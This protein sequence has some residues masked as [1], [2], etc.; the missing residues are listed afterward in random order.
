MSKVIVPFALCKIREK[1][2][3][4]KNCS[5]RMMT[6]AIVTGSIKI[7]VAAAK[8][9]RLGWMSKARCRSI[10]PKK[11]EK[12][13]EDRHGQRAA[14]SSSGW[15]VLCLCLPMWHVACARA[16]LVLS[17]VAFGVW[18]FFITRRPPPNSF[19]RP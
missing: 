7:T 16:R 14:S 3:E 1:L 19:F 10:M 12:E 11:K 9:T 2:I 6:A 5:H 8:K 18:C 15:L 17:L 4:K 13:G